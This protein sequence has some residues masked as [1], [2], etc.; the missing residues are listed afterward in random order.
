LGPALFRVEALPGDGEPLPV[1]VVTFPEFPVPDAPWTVLILVDYPDPGEVIFQPP[2]FPPSL[3]LERVFTGGRII[4][5]PDGKAERRAAAEFSFILRQAGSLDLEPFEIRAGDKRA[6]TPPFHFFVQDTGAPLREGPPVFLWETPPLPLSVGES[7]DFALLLASRDPKRPLPQGDLFR[8]K[9]PGEFILETKPLSDADRERGLVSRFRLIPLTAGDFELGP[10]SFYPQ[11]FPEVP[12]L[13]IRVRDLSGK[14][15]TADLNR[16]FPPGG[17]A[18][19]DFRE[20]ESPIPFPPGKDPRFPPLRAGYERTRQSA[21]KLWEGGK[22]AE[23]LAVLR[24][25]ERDLFS[26]PALVLLRQDTERALSLEPGENEKWRPLVFLGFLCAGS[27]ISLLF[28]LG[29]G[30]YFFSFSAPF[31]RKKDVTSPRMRRYKGR[32]LFFAVIF[33]AAMWGLGDG[34]IRRERAEKEPERGCR[35]IL[36]AVAARRVPDPGGSV[37]L[38]FGEGQSVIVRGASNAWVYV[39]A[40][41]GRMGWIPG[42]RL[43]LY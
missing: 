13:S 34:I 24:R 17:G 41:G 29:P 43:I 16:D 18:S 12:V 42:D 11:D 36:R 35:G 32:A 33:V 7:G 39:E 37:D 15:E 4:P 14:G 8:G 30:L 6:F 27:F 25:G 9:A 3:T 5:G 1:E 28:T 23:A 10:F 2:S 38:W 20:E 26:G 40:P 22:Q 19:P 21:R 31:S